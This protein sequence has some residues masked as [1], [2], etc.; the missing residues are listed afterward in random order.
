MGSVPADSKAALILAAGQGKRM[1][2]ARPKVLHEVAGRPLLSWVLAAAREAGLSPIGIVV[3]PGDRRE[4]ERAF[5]GEDLLWFEQA[6]SLGTGHAVLAARPLLTGS[7]QVAVLSGDVPL[8]RA[9]TLARLLEAAAG[10]AGALAVAA[11]AEPGNLGRVLLR[12]GDRL[13]RIVEARDAGPEELAIP[14]VN[15]GAY[16]VAGQALLPYL[17]RLEPHNAQGELYFTDALSALAAAGQELVAVRLEDPA[18]AWGVND[19]RELARAHRRLIDRK[20][21][22]LQAAGVTVLE[23]DRTSV[24]PGVAVGRDTV[25]HPGVHLQGST[26]LGEGVVVHAG[27]WVRDSEVAAEAVL[28]PY[29]VLDGARVGP[30]CRIGPFARLRPGT[31]LEAGVRVGNFV[32]TK[33]ATLRAGAKALHLAYLGDAEVGEEANIGAGT[34][35]CN[36]DGERKHRTE[37][38][39]GAFIGSDTMLVAP[40]RVGGRAAT[41]AGSVITQDVPDGA[42][43]VERAAQRVVPGWSERR[44]RKRQGD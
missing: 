35:T 17:E 3:R 21:E 28:E 22:E 32:E 41:G 15:A 30:G 25:L 26:R 6:E 36:F 2:S 31:V 10:R 23:P 5:S 4:L 12:S 33:A 16:V 27:C 42:L 19:R 29:S 1:R 34:I 9:A 40:V 43:A 14:L 8:L 38:G 20:L 39:P 37:I 24:E 44:R 18:E 13:E 7:A 11:L